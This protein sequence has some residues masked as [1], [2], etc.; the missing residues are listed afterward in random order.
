M[1]DPQLENGYTQIANELMEC[2]MRLHLSPNH[3]RVLLCIIRKTYG[4][5]KKVD[6]IANFQIA[7]ATG[8]CKAVVSRSLK[9][10]NNQGLI[11]RN[12]KH[13]GFKKD[14]GQWEKLAVLS[15]LPEGV[16]N[17]V[18]K[19][20]AISSTKVSSP[21]VAQKKPLKILIKDT[22]IFDLWNSLGIVKHKTLTPEMKR[23]IKTAMESYSQEDIC[24]AIQNYA[25]ILADDIYFFK[26]R[27]T[28]RDFLRRGLEKFMDLEVAKQNYSDRNHKEAGEWNPR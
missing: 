24:G 6:Y 17:I 13:I 26:Y 11:T 5:H 19:E 7:K 27:W 10:L 15:T 21:A 16:S 22:Y 25:L 2:L 4:F 8:L 1:A 3:W 20:L 9:S 18:N 14:W 28:L 12:G 23:A